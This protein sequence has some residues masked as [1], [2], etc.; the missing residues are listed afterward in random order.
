MAPAHAYPPLD[1][2]AYVALRHLEAREL[3][4]RAELLMHA[5]I[6]TSAAG[7]LAQVRAAILMIA[8][9]ALPSDMEEDTPEAAVAAL[10]AYRKRREE[11][12]YH[13][14]RDHLDHDERV[15]LLY[16][17]TVEK[18]QTYHA[19]G[20]QRRIFEPGP[21]VERASMFA[22][23]EVERLRAWRPP[24]PPPPQAPR[25]PAARRPAAARKPSAPSSS[26]SSALSPKTAEVQIGQR[27]WTLVGEALVQVEITG[28]T[29]SPSGRTEFRVRRVDN[30]AYLPSARS[31]A[32]L[33]RR[34][35]K[36][37]G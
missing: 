10:R 17:E 22:P 15:L 8:N 37:P 20:R 9:D 36:H 19:R 35:E 12:A 27:Y 2:R 26:S 13:H 31:A 11:I 1:D 5:G 18:I 29:A 32:K 16:V 34:P 7:T 33:R 3:R 14:R 6:Y 28:R 24:P 23:S 25:P 21:V 30:G 4:L